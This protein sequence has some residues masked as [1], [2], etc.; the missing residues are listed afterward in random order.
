METTLQRWQIICGSYAGK[1]AI[2]VE[3]LHRIVSEY[4]DYVIPIH[5]ADSVDES[6]PAIV[7]GTPESNPLIAGFLE[8][9]VLELPRHS[10]G[11][12]LKSV[13]N[14]K[15][16]QLL[17]IG[18]RDSQ[19]LLYA[20]QDF[21]DR[22]LV[23]CQESG[24]HNVYFRKL[25]SG[26]MPELSMTSVPAIRERA[27]WTWGYV[28]YD[29][30]K[31]LDNM[32]RL[33]LNTLVCWNDCAPL[34][35]AE[36]VSYAHDR[37]I[38]VIWGYSWGWGVELGDITKEETLLEWERRAVEV[39]EQDYAPLGGD[40]IYFQSFTE[41]EAQELNGVPIADTVT[42]WVNRIS[43]S[44]LERFLELNIQFG[45]HATSVTSRLDAIRAIDSRVTIVWE[46][47]GAFPY[48][49]LPQKV[50]NLEET[51]S[52]SEKIS[53]LRA[54][55]EKFGVVFKG[56]TTLDWTRFEHHEGPFLLGERSVRSKAAKTAERAADWKLLQAY[57][58]RNA[59]AMHKVVSLL[60]QKKNGDYSAQLLIED[61]MLEEKIFFPAAVAA[62]L[63]WNTDRKMEDL[64]CETALCPDICFAN[65]V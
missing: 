57:W 21:S 33:K 9:G 55:D 22:Y 50:E 42:L 26:D 11:Y 28:I 32:V 49:Y 65:L 41:T 52:L 12:T 45:L 24:T 18:A 36:I 20:V 6:R 56:M 43:S 29:Y 62:S 13:R 31:F 16:V 15:G 51:L 2:A 35:G 25:F 17:L 59:D 3:L 19:G 30:R 39:Y 4:T 14:P 8:K 53:S 1:E 5:T 38:K 34:N 10:E 23:T 54:A 60:N 48:H 40:G 44:L 37:G 63:L 64:L 27:I 7:I 58:L 47:A 46:D 61:G